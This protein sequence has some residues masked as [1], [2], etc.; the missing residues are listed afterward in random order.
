[1]GFG[2]LR[3]PVAQL[4][5]LCRT[6]IVRGG[7]ESLLASLPGSLVSYVGRGVLLVVVDRDVV[8]LVV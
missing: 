1:M 6:R 3:G 7:G 5:A 8:L 2:W 4:P